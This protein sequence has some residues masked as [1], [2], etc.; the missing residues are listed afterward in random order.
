MKVEAQDGTGVVLGEVTL[1]LIGF[2]GDVLL[3]VV[4]GIQR[5]YLS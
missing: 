3:G 1:G 4:R 5:D 2:P